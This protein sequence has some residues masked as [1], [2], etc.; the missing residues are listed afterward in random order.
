MNRTQY[1]QKIMVQRKY[2][3]WYQKDTAPK[4]EIEPESTTEVDNNFKM[5]SENIVVEPDLDQL[6]LH[7]NFDSV[8]SPGI[9]E[10]DNDFRMAFE[11][12]KP[13]LEQLDQQHENWDSAGSS[14][15]QEAKAHGQ[16][17]PRQGLELPLNY[18]KRPKRCISPVDYTEL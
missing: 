3:F 13:D 4:I 7:E 17:R 9:Q 16:K 10:V 14:G 1:R 18:T 5:T 11:D 12:V 8:V 6:M 15:I 2:K